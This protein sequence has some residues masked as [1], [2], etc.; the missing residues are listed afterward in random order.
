MERDG[1]GNTGDTRWTLQGISGR[2]AENLKQVGLGWTNGGKKDRGIAWGTIRG[3][4]E[5]LF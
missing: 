4:G 2:K 5:Q 1:V 3:L